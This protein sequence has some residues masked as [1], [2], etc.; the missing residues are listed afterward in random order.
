MSLPEME[1]LSCRIPDPLKVKLDLPR[2]RTL[3]G[4][5]CWNYFRATISGTRAYESGLEACLRLLT[6]AENH[7]DSLTK[8]EYE[9]H[10]Q[11]LYLGILD[12][13]DKLDRWEEY[14]LVWDNLRS[15]TVLVLP[16]PRRPP[17]FGMEPF[18]LRDEGNLIYVHFLWHTAHRRCLIER[19]LAKLR[20]GKKLGNLLH[21][22]QEELS[23]FEIRARWERVKQRMIYA[24]KV[25]DLIA[26]VRTA[27]A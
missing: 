8:E 15:N 4:Y 27:Q 14:A 20:A 22:Q 1:A 2:Y 13:L 16:Q 26:R 5:P 12:M 9:G 7:R 19:K 23:D 21:S 3:M 25:N 10:L 17:S 18:T 11:R 24:E 6:F